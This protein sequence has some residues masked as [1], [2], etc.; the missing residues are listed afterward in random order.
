[1]IVA[2]TV[3]VMAANDDWIVWRAAVL[4]LVQMVGTND[5]SWFVHI[6][7]NAVTWAD[8]EMGSINEHTWGQCETNGADPLTWVS[9]ER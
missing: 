4:R 5:I 7:A 8:F 6:Y 3:P 1:M 2:F 9:L